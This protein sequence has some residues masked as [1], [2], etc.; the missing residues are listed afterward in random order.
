MVVPNKHR[1]E[2]ELVLNGHSYTV[3]P[4]MDKLA[5][6]EGRFGAALVL[7]RRLQNGEVTQAELAALTAIMVR[8]L[9]NA[10]READLPQLI[11]DEGSPNVS[12]N[13]LT[14]VLNGM[15]SDVGQPASDEGTEHENPR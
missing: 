11:F 12:G 6:I 10:P 15:S 8:G 9:P 3:R 4:T 1:K 5:R 14:F 2:S 13:V 7:L